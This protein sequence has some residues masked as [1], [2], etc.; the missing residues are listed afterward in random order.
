MDQP[1]YELSRL[2]TGLHADS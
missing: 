1:N 2:G